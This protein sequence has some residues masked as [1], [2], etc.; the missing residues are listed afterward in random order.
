MGFADRMVRVLLLVGLL[1]A[2]PGA[3]LAKGK[4][5]STGDTKTD[6][7]MVALQE[8]T[9]A[10]EAC[11]G[12]M[13]TTLRM[14]GQ[15]VAIQYDAAF[16]RPNRIRL[17]LIQAGAVLATIVSDGGLLWV[18][19]A[20]EK[21]VTKV[22]RSRVY[23]ATELEADA[24]QPDPIR[25][26]RGLVWPSIRYAGDETVGA[27]T[28]RVFEALPK[29]NPMQAQLPVAPVKVKIYVDSEDGLL[30]TVRSYDAAGAEIMI[31]QFSDVRV[32]PNLADSRFEFV[33]PAGAHVIDATD[34]TVQLLKALKEKE[35]A[36][37]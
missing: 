27:R 9:K 2:A 12:K 37:Q 18:Y 23:R 36:G 15:E 28:L 1:G 21:L 7:M 5:L 33:I 19:E 11:T 32:T 8:K 20:G 26:F 3:A 30:R 4:K 6:G 31:Q 24:D 22:N 35:Q 13:V 14:M 29:P 25:P 16:K 34:D 17:D 10:V